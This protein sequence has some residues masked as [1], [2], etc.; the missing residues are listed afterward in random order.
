MFFSYLNLMDEAMWWGTMV[1]F[2]PM[3]FIGL[4]GSDFIHASL[5]IATT[6]H[7]GD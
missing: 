7:K 5:D 6:K 1:V 3:I 4:C 2:R